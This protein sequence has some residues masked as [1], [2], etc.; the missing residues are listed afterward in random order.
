MLDRSASMAFDLSSNEF[1]YPSDVSSNRTPL[2]CYF[3]PP[4]ASASRWASLTAAVNEFVSVL[5]SRNLDVHVALVTYAEN[6]TFGTYSATESSVD[7]GLTSN[8]SSIVTAMNNYGANPLL[9]DTNISAGL[10]AA[11]GVLTGTGSRLN[12]NRTIILL[13]D[14]VATTGNTNIP[15]IAASYLSSYDIV[16]D[17]ITF[18]AEANTPTAQAA[19]QGAATSGNG[20]YFYAPTAAQLQTAFQTIAD[21]IPAVL[22]K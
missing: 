16:M 2:Q 22:I 11:Q 8:T 15:A 12:A 5:Q 9:G 4:S 17:T 6:Y 21:S 14:G 20:M 1:S 10:A 3:Y 7:V 19:M 13:T 18:S